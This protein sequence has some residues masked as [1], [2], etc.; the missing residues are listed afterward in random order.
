MQT[1]E[2]T[3]IKLVLVAHPQDELLK[4]KKVTIKDLNNKTLIFAKS[5]CNYKKIIQK[6]LIQSDVNPQKIIEINSLD[7]IK[8][9]LVLGSGVAFLPEIIITDELN[10]GLLQTLNWSGTG[11]NAKL[12][13][14]WA[15]EKHISEPLHAFMMMVKK[16]IKNSARLGD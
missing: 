13:M 7:A 15:K 5:E 16:M 8:R 9:L 10:K 14:I 4:N 1:E 12:I 2:L 11:F 3:V 6:M